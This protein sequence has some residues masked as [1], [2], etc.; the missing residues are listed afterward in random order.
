MKDCL[1][2]YNQYKINKTFNRDCE[3]YKSSIEL[4]PKYKDKCVWITAMEREINNFRDSLE[5]I[6]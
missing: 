6:M 2:C 4:D 3:F 5:N 1:N